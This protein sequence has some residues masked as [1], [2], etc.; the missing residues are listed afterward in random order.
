M[1]EDDKDPEVEIVETP[2]IDEKPALEVDITEPEPKKK[3]EEPVKK[4]ESAY[5]RDELTKLKN[6]QLY[7][8][9]QFE[10][11]LREQKEFIENIKKTSVMPKS[12]SD[13]P[14]DKEVE[15]VAQTNWQKAVDMR[16]EKVAERIAEQKLQERVKKYQEEQV[17]SYKTQLV[18]RSKSF[19]LSQY[20]QLADE[21]SEEARVFNQ[22][23]NENQSLWQNPEGFRLAMYEMEERMRSSGRTPNR[24]KQEVDKEVR[25]QLRAGA[26]SVVG[27][28]V[29]NGKV[30]L[31][32]EQLEVCEQ[33]GIKPEA[34]AKTM[35]SLENKEDI[36]I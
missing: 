2:E 11:V 10:K 6:R 9:R 1:L 8:D 23:W 12:D 20:P 4:Q 27:R 16:A 13:D 25:R 17:Q 29:N 3:A 22:V 35:R 21:N 28:S 34:Y 33:L 26:S 30:T 24:V 19:V 32:K 15:Q 36:T 18:E 7:L 5:D 14:F 31:T